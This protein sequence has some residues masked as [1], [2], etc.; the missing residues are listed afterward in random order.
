MRAKIQDILIQKEINSVPGVGNYSF[1][2]SLIKI[3][4]VFG[5]EKRKIDEKVKKNDTISSASYNFGDVFKRIKSA[6][7][8][9]SIPRTKK[10]L[11]TE[12]IS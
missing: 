1:G 12:R 10:L 5:R 6:N 2:S 3:G 11:I 4:T 8:I 9:Y 7:P